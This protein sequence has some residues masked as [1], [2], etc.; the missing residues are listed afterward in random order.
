MPKSKP[1]KKPA[2]TMCALTKAAVLRAKSKKEKAR[3]DAMR[4]RRVEPLKSNIPHLARTIFQKRIIRNIKD[5]AMT[6]ESLFR[7][8]IRL[9]RFVAPNGERDLSRQLQR[10]LVTA[11]FKVENVRLEHQRLFFDPG[12]EDGPSNRIDDHLTMKLFV[13][14]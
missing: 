10:L 8:S 9:P 13:S 12:F 7:V 4:M 6:G 2:E 11:G 5:A 14:W 1:K 3:L